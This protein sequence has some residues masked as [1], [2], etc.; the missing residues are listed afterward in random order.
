MSSDL[1]VSRRIDK[2]HAGS[3]YSVAWSG[4]LIASGSNDQTIKLTHDESSS[5]RS[6]NRIKLQ[7]GTVRGLDFHS[8]NTIVLF[9]GCSGD[10]L[11]RQIDPVPG[12]VVGKFAC[13]PSSSLNDST[14][15][16]TV[17]CGNN[18]VVCALS[19]GAVVAVDDRCSFVPWRISTGNTSAC[20]HSNGH[21]V[22][23]GTES[24]NVGLYDM[25]VGGSSS[26]WTSNRAHGGACRSVS[27]SHSS[28]EPIVASASFDKK[29][30]LWKN[31]ENFTT[32]EGQHSDRVV[33]VRWSPVTDPVLVSCGTDSSVLL[34]EQDGSR[35]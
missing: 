11:L 3:V 15:I 14:F 35:I 7:S 21:Y 16:N 6:G 12:T 2:L 19:N 33:C 20:A 5:N 9:A 27:V 31:G 17:C 25:R 8:F 23:I 18:V 10:S 34:W 24:G 4:S 1:V 22:A 29:I 32:M 28:E 26:L 30:K 13:S